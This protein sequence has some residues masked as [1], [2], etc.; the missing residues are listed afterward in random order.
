MV[1]Q[2]YVTCLALCSSCSWSTPCLPPV[3]RSGVEG[4]CAPRRSPPTI[5]TIPLGDTCEVTTT[6]KEIFASGS[7]SPSTSISSR[8]MTPAGL[9][10][11]R[12]MTALTVSNLPAPGKG[13]KSLVQRV[14]VT[15]TASG[16]NYYMG[17]ASNYYRGC[18]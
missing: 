11:P 13:V 10:G 2:A 3:M 7:S 14:G 16:G 12:R 5:P 4:Q 18:G 15:G 17:T 6:F 8:S 1:P 9:A